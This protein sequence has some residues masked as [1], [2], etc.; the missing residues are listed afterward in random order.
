MITAGS[1]MMVRGLAARV[2]PDR[3][4]AH[5]SD[6]A[7][8]SLAPVGKTTP[9]APGERSDVAGPPA[10]VQAPYLAHDQTP[11]AAI[12]SGEDTVAPTEPP[13]PSVPPTPP[14]EAGLPAVPVVDQVMKARL[15]EIHARGLERGMRPDVFAKIG[16][17]ITVSTYF[18][19][20]FG[21]PGHTLGDHANLAETI[22]YF[23]TVELQGAG[24][25]NGCDAANAF[26]R[27]SLAAGR[28][29]IAV[30]VLS[31][32]PAPPAD[33]PPPDDTPLRCELRQIRPSIALVML[34]TNDLHQRV[35]VRGYRASLA[36]IASEL[37]SAGV[38]PVLSTIPHRLDSQAA[39]ARVGDYNA[40][41]RS[42]AEEAGLPLWN[43]WRALDGSD[44]ARGGMEPDGVHPNAYAHGGSLT[45]RGL[46]YGHNQRNLT[47][48]QLLDK[49]RRIVIED[50]TPED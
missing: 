14:V 33:C 45:E 13:S 32:M 44:M 8:R 23:Q 38:I 42:V 9:A 48:L 30:Q 21:C 37:E 49:L 25:A 40:A 5:G 27:A 19:T 12:G 50:G 1:V 34:G 7:T 20:P 31:P 35:G 22:A 15:R 43:Y 28:G 16:D 4:G 3:T 10:D 17:S 41:V 11:V 47:A 24:A 39:N 6:A 26:T 29:W 18:L 36:T 46:R 2:T